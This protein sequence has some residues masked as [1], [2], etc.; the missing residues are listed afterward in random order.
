MTLLP[1]DRFVIPPNRFS[2]LSANG[3]DRDFRVAPVVVPREE[4]E[5]RLDRDAL[6]RQVRVLNRPAF[7]GTSIKGTRSAMGAFVA[8]RHVGSAYDI[9]NFGRV[10]PLQR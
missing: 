5:L 1:K 2:L 6:A 8:Q 7:F 10:R 4:W 3:V 9:Q